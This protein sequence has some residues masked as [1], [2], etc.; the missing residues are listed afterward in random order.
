MVQTLTGQLDSD[1]TS[2]P[3]VPARLRIAKENKSLAVA[4]SS[5]FKFAV[6]RDGEDRAKLQSIQQ[7]TWVE[8]FNGDDGKVYNSQH[9]PRES[10]NM[11]AARA[12]GAMVVPG[13]SSMPA[14]GRRAARRPG[15]A[16]IRR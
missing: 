15:F 1:S 14:R 5:L 4:R 6:F 9:R 7:N 3:D 8:L 16:P 10:G 12:V 11:P 2:V 13:L